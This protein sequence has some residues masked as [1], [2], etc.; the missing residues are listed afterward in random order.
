MSAPSHKWDIS[1]KKHMTIE[2][3]DQLY[4]LPAVIDPSEVLLIDRDHSLL[5]KISI[6]SISFQVRLKFSNYYPVLL[7]L[8]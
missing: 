3:A 2:S 7:R 4:D 8:L 5:S 1:A 6:T